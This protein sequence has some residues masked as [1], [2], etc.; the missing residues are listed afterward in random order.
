MEGRRVANLLTAYRTLAEELDA[1]I[2]GK[3]DDTY[4][5]MLLNAHVALGL[6]ILKITNKKGSGNGENEVAQA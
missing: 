6:R 3:E 1:A 5:D 2:D 4:V